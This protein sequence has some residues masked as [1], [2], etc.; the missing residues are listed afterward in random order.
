MT[1]QG[2]GQLRYLGGRCIAKMQYSTV[3]RLRRV[4]YTNSTAYTHEK[5]KLHALRNLITGEGQLKATTTMPSSLDVTSS[6]QNINRSLL[7]ISDEAQHFFITLHDAVRRIQDLEAFAKHGSD[8]INVVR[9][10]VLA[11]GVVR[12][13]FFKCMRDVDDTDLINILFSDCVTRFLAVSSNQYRKALVHQLR[14]KKTAAHRV[15]IQKASTSRIEPP[16]KKT[17]RSNNLCNMCG[18]RYKLCKHYM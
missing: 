7:N 6:K 18:G 13:A 2:L 17:K 8:V 5:A 16:A 11:N 15:E 12:E 3:T 10:Q 9:Q 4:M 14:R 1:D